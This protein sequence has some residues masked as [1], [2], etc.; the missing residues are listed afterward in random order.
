MI[1]DILTCTRYDYTEK[2]EEKRFKKNLILIIIN[3]NT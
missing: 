3:E 2:N 1:I